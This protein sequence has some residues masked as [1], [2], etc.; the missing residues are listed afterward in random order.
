MKAQALPVIARDADLSNPRPRPV[1]AGDRWQQALVRT[2]PYLF[3]LAV[4][5]VWELW[6]RL[7][8]VPAYLCPGPV[9]IAQ[10][11]VRDSAILLPSLW[12]TAR[13]T[14]VA[15][16]AAA[17][18]G[19]LL[20]VL[21]AS[22]RWIERTLF[23]YAVILQVTPT[24]AIAP[25]III[26]AKDT[27][28]ALLICAWLIAF[29]PIL[30]NTTVGLNS[31]DPN[32]A[33]LFRLYGASRWQS[34][35]W[36]RLPGALPYFLAGLRISGGLALVGAVVAEFVAGTGG[37]QSGLAYRILESGYRLNIPHMFAALTLISA[38]GIAIFAALSLLSRI[39][40]RH[41]PGEEN[42]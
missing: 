42:R 14:F 17:A 15:F 3:G 13:V 9:L 37:T 1:T 12:F 25:L 36:L 4:L 31:V 22:S 19:L 7:W 20:S 38:M 39:L 11:I 29:F 6:T 33:D 32:L 16:F 23:P 40:L 30:S 27:Q 21:F 5:A 34:M 41:R 28:F 35:L 10:T 18:G 24:V 26:W 2:L 8:D